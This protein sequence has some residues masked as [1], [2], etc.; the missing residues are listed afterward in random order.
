MNKTLL[1]TDT[2]SEIGKG[3]HPTVARNAVA[4]RKAYGYYTLSTVTVME[5][6]SGHQRRQAVQR[7]ANFLASIAREE[8]IPFDQGA[9][10]LAGRI[11][12]GDCTISHVPNSTCSR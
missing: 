1:D 10:E 5:I 6:V 3:I 2:L 7:I 4:Y 11:T 8:V 12:Q 9:A